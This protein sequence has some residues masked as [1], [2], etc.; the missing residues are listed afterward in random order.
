MDPRK[1][2]YRPGFAWFFGRDSF[3][4]S[5]ALTAAGDFANARSAI[6]FVARYQREDG[7]IPHEISQSASL[8]PWFKDY[9]W[10]YASADATPLFV[11]AVRDY[12]EASGDVE[13]A[14]RQWPRLVKAFEFMRST[15]GAGGFPKNFGVGH[16]WVEGGPLL[17]VQ[18]E[19]Y[20]AGC[21]VEA[22]RSMAKLARVT[23]R[24]ESGAFD[25][26]F[27]DKR[28]TLDS[29]FWL[30]TDSTYAF[31]LDSQGRPIDQPSVL[32]TVPMWF[33]LLDPAK[34]RRMIESLAAETHQTDWGMRIIGSNSPQFGPAGYHYGSVWPL[35]TGWASVAEYRYHMPE[36]A[37]ANL[38]A[39][40]WLALDGAGG[41]T[42]EVLSGAT[43]SPLSTGSPHQIW[44]AA[45]VV[46]PILRGLLGLSVDET[47][48]RVTFA[49]HLPADW[50]RLGV[51][52]IRVGQSTIDIA[53]TRTP[54]RDAFE[55]THHGW[56][57][58]ELDLAPAYAPPVQITT[59]NPTSSERTETDWHP[60]FRI[61]LQ[62]G[63]NTVAIEHTAALGYTMPWQPPVLAN[64]SANLKMIS[65]RWLSDA[66]ELRLT[67]LP[68]R[69][70]SI[71]LT[72]GRR[73]PVRIAGEGPVY[74]ETTIRIPL[75]P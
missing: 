3:W 65:E 13:F 73:I 48:N 18:V 19:L 56:R 47:A 30:N 74:R 62:P 5:F 16:G 46:S 24:P 12:V 9:P 72:D 64:T 75:K 61:T 55:I 70:Y 37:L 49:P 71:A 8:L 7:K 20:Q 17:P 63:P 58:V 11:I 2:L 36:A 66:L 53:W 28:P 31:A 1:A 69:D 27:N 57:P 25:R 54:T 33:G 40:A 42:T 45:M 26:E 10:A 44:S 38:R 50:P 23:G 67:G 60:H 6:D 59:P 51:R 29:L 43:Y 34:S 41:N 32:T 35:F 39:N 52:N 14:R 4:I 22:L 15:A 21:Y 68:G